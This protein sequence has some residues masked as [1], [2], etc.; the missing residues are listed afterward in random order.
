VIKL[1]SG[2]KP[3]GWMC[4]RCLFRNGSSSRNQAGRAVSI[5][6]WLSLEAP[7]KLYQVIAWKGGF[8]LRLLRAVEVWRTSFGVPAS[9]AMHVRSGR[10]SH[11]W[12]VVPEMARITLCTDLELP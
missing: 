4:Q 7:I 9:F 6:R 5:S 3:S 8:D 10:W 2:G 11:T 1:A 12:F